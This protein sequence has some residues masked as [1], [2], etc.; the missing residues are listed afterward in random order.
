M[1][2]NYE[3]TVFK[4]KTIHLSEAVI[5]NSVQNETSVCVQNV[6][7]FLTEEASFKTSSATV[8]GRWMLH[9]APISKTNETLQ[10]Y[11]HLTWTHNFRPYWQVC[12]S[13]CRH[14]DRQQMLTARE[15]REGS[16]Y[17]TPE[18]VETTL[19]ICFIR[20]TNLFSNKRTGGQ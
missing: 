20:K 6:K 1:R 18:A 13:Q 9:V 2:V 19:H 7:N 3:C 12:S 14:G 10:C 17:G 11:L 15:N 8:A 5:T 16:K 4:N